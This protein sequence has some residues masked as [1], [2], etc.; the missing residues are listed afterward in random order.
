LVDRES[1]H[2]FGDLWF[3]RGDFLFLLYVYVI[4]MIVLSVIE[5]AY[6]HQY[7]RIS[8]SCAIA[9]VSRPTAD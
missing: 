2:V 9:A 7:R 1:C 3:V 8:N 4:W 6:V 5:V